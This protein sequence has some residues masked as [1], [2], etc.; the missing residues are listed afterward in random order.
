M[1]V[2]R[3]EKGFLHVGV[4]TDGTSNPLDLGFGAVVERKQGDFVGARSLQR[5][6]DRRADRRQFVGFEVESG[7]VLAGAHFVSGPKGTGRSEGFVTSA[8]LSPTLGKHI[9]LGLLE[10]GFQR[11][12]E[13]L[14]VFDAGEAVPV[15]IIDS[16]FYDP[17]GGRMR[18]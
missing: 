17:D 14:Y 2:L 3:M 11:R 18:G 6:A 10:R 15:R 9:G 4:D 12:G 8:C 16:R 5:P 13:R 7:S 1:L